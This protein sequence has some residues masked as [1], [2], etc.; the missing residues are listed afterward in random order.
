MA[1][2]NCGPYRKLVQGISTYGPLI[3]RVKLS[4]TEFA[5]GGFNAVKP[6][7]Y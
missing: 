2:N 5:Q 4:L 7:T 1:V 3:N 6:T